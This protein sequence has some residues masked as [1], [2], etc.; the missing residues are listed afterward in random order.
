MKHRASTQFELI[1][2]ANLIK[3]EY[4][5]IK[6][7]IDEL[8][9]V[10]YWRCPYDYCNSHHDRNRNLIGHLRDTKIHKHEEDLSNHINILLT[11]KNRYNLINRY[12]FQDKQKADEIRR[13]L[14]LSVVEK[15]HF[16]N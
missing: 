9:L 16:L 8:H 14:R 7:L 5:E 1:E 11:E 3:E 13:K 4:K 15:F 12:Y 6:L 2:R 10:Q